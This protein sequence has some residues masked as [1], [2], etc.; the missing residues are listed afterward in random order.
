MV[1][2][3]NLVDVVVV[4]KAISIA[5]WFKDGISKLLRVGPFLRGLN[6]LNDQTQFAILMLGRYMEA[7]EPKW[8]NPDYI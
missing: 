4:F 2:V 5:N 6:E 1:L 7:S 8:V 3:D